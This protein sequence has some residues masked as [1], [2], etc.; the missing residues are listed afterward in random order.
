MACAYIL[1]DNPNRSV[2]IPSYIDPTDRGKS[3]FNFS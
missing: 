1:G 2:L 3:T